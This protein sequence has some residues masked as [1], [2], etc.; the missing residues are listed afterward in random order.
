MLYN[1]FEVLFLTT[2]CTGFW[3]RVHNS[4]EIVKLQGLF[5]LTVGYVDIKTYS[6]T[7]YYY[8]IETVYCIYR[9]FVATTVIGY[10]CYYN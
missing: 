8:I 10:Y 9:L 5:V 1:I 4:K 6:L 3:K 7:K 2:F